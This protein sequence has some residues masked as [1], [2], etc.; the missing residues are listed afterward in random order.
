LEGS[1]GS[2]EQLDVA[3]WRLRGELFLI[4]VGGDDT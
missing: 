1:R 2:F 4:D 3:L